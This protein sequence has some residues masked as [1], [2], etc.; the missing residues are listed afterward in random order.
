M[1]LI[2]SVMVS[3]RKEE[4]NYGEEL[5]YK[6]SCTIF[7]SLVPKFN[8]IFMM[9]SSLQKMIFSGTMIQNNMVQTQMWW[10][11]LCIIKF[12]KARPKNMI[13]VTVGG[14]RDLHE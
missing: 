7:V 2:E 9:L 13:H 6:P 14:V 5:G 12:Y 11:F 4:M 8:E 10:S 1:G 3:E